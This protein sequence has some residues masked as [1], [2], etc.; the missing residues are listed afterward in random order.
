MPAELN[1]R[2]R[3]VGGGLVL[4]SKAHMDPIRLGLTVRKGGANVIE[5]SEIGGENLT[6]HYDGGTA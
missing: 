6:F 2:V 3:L 1:A 5:Q 4:G